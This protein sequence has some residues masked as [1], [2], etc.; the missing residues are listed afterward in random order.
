MDLLDIIGQVSILI[1]VISFYYIV[2]KVRMHNSIVNDAV[3]NI[4]LP[5]IDLSFI[6]WV[7]KE[8]IVI[9]KSKILVTVSIVSGLISLT[10]ALYV[11]IS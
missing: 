10:I 2:R 1:Y 3:R 5:N 11:L 4:L 7:Y 6:P 9:T 8:Y